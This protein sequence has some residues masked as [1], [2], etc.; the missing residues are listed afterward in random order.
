MQLDETRV[1]RDGRQLKPNKDDLKKR[2][3]LQDIRS[4]NTNQT[5]RIWD[6]DRKSL[7][8]NYRSYI[9]RTFEPVTDEQMDK[10]IPKGTRK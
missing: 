7:V 8:E 3:D 2:S 10:K 6:R 1:T 5:L 9:D 4:T